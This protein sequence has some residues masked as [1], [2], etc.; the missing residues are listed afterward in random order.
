MPHY[1]SSLFQRGYLDM[2]WACYDDIRRA[3]ASFS[4]ANIHRRLRCVEWPHPHNADSG[5]NCYVNHQR[6]LFG[7]DTE[8]GRRGDRWPRH[9]GGTSRGIYRLVHGFRP[10]SA[11]VSGTAELGPCPASREFYVERAPRWYAPQA[12]VPPLG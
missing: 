11:S 1:R 7:P 3:S 4:S 6:H 8:G 9:P 12:T 5:S 2:L 10:E